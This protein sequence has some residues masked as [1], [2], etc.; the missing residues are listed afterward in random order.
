MND[1]IQ[2]PPELYKYDAQRKGWA[3]RVITYICPDCG[4][5]VNQPVLSVYQVNT[6]CNCQYPHHVTQMVLVR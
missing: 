6:I 2:F 1:G 3:L 5:T 4:R